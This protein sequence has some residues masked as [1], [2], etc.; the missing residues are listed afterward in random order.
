[1]RKQLDLLL[2]QLNLQRD[3]AG[4]VASRP[5]EARHIAPLN[6][7]VIDCNDDDRNGTARADDGLQRD[8]GT[9]G[10]N[11]IWVQPHQLRRGDKRAAWVIQVSIINAY[12]LALVEAK[13]AQAVTN[14]S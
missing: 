2:R 3:H 12:I 9:E 7:I 10:N 8:F 14:A 5:R 13:L 6:R 4:D 11:Q 1:M